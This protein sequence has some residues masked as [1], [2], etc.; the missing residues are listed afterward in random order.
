MAKTIH[1]LRAPFLIRYFHHP[2]HGRS[3]LNHVL[4]WC[5]LPERFQNT[6]AKEEKVKAFDLQRQEPR[7]DRLQNEPS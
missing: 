1:I 7:K 3:S 2:K 6:I 4:A 5:T